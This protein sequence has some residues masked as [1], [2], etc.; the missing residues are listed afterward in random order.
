MKGR[1]EGGVW[2]VK[3]GEKERERDSYLLIHSPTSGNVP[4]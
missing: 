2:G 3:K 1:R 4:S